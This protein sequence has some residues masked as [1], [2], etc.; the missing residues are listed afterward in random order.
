MLMLVHLL[1]TLADATLTRAVIQMQ[2]NPL[3]SSSDA[4]GLD[5]LHR[6]YLVRLAAQL[7]ITPQNLFHR[8]RRK[9]R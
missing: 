3:A 6:V 1:A 8:R 2:P 9:L 4:L 5:A 7:G